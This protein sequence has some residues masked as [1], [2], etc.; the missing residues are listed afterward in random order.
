MFIHTTYTYMNIQEYN[1]NVERWQPPDKQHKVFPTHNP[2]M[3]P[4]KDLVDVGKC[5]ISNAATV[6]TNLQN[7]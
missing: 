2:H 5:C 7:A 4:A 3:L 6:V 1:C